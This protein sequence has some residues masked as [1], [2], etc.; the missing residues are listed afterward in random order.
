MAFGS[1][2]TSIWGVQ[3][4]W[5]ATGVAQCCGYFFSLLLCLFSGVLLVCLVVHF[6]PHL[7]T[8][9]YQ[10][11]TCTV[12]Q[13]VYTVQYSCGGCVH[14]QEQHDTRGDGCHT[15]YPCLLV[16]VLINSS[17]AHLDAETREQL[18]WPVLAYEDDWQQ[19]GVYRADE[20]SVERVSCQRTE[21]HD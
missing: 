2:P 6:L 7:R 16:Y 18:R 21:A 10:E 13:T 19:I 9:L 15:F 3:Q 14:L 20:G 8:V 11:A 1:R 12:L 5:V 17:A 4:H